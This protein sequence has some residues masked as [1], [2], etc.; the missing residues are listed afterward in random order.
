[1]PSKVGRRRFLSTL[2][3]AYALSTVRPS[4]ASTVKDLI[5][6]IAVE[7]PFP[8]RKLGMTWFHPRPC[9]L[10]SGNGPTVLMTMQTIQGSDNFGPVHWTSTSDLGKTWSKPTPI[11]GFERREFDKPNRGKDLWEEGVCD[12]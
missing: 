2:A 8:G 1:M 5:E 3:S 7:T 9:V 4:P 12:V 10:P 6:G 11:P